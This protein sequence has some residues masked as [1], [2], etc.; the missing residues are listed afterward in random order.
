VINDK[1]EMSYKQLQIWQQ[2]QQLVEEI[3]HMTLHELPKF[4]MFET[5]SQIRRSVKSVK[6]NIVE[7]YGR[8]IYKQQYLYFLVV[9]QASNDETID[10]LETLFITG[11]LNDREKYQDL[12][13]KLIIL[14]KKI[15]LFIT[16]VKHDYY[17]N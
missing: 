4:E 17:K 5:G 7:G 9:A 1:D 14:G 16:A 15:N 2:A 11:S 6:A 8:R 12:K 10:H 13:D 3:H